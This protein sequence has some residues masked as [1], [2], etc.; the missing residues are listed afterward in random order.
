MLSGG[1]LSPGDLDEF[2]EAFLVYSR[3]RGVE[4]NVPITFLRVAFFRQGFLQGYNS[5]DYDGI[6]QATANLK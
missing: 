4:G 5:C 3:E 6:A 2:I 1:S